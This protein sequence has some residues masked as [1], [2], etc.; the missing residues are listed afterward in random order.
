MRAE[1]EAQ[2]LARF[3]EDVEA[4]CVGK[5]VVVAVRRRDARQHY[6]PRADGLPEQIEVFEAMRGI[7]D[8]GVS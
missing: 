1:A 2:I 3:A 8:T 6:P 4:V 7:R 5:V